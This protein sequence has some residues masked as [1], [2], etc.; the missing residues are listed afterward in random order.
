MEA[1]P[2]QNRQEVIVSLPL[3]VPNDDKIQ[4]IKNKL[5]TYFRSK[6]GCYCEVECIRLFGGDDCCP[7][8]RVV[9]NEQSGVRNVLSRPDHAIVVDGIKIA[10]K[11]QSS[12]APLGTL[13][14]PFSED[15]S[16]SGHFG[17][18][19]RAQHQ[20]QG[21]VSG[22]S[23]PQGSTTDTNFPSGFKGYPCP[24]QSRRKKNTQ[25]LFPNQ[26]L[27]NQFV[28]RMFVRPFPGGK[29][30]DQTQE[31]YPISF[32][33]DQIDMPE[34]T[35]PFTPANNNPHQAQT[36]STSAGGLCESATFDHSVPGVTNTVSGLNVVTNEGL[37][38]KLTKGS[39]AMET[40]DAI[41]NT[42]GSDLDMK[43][44]MVSQAIFQ[45][46]GPTLQ[47]E[48]DFWKDA[49]GSVAQ[50]SFI[51][52]GP[53]RLNCQKIYH[54]VC[55]GYKQFKSE[56]LLKQLVVNLMIYACS[57]GMTS[58]AIPA[59]GTGRLNYPPAV[60]AR[61]MYEAAF[62]FSSQHPN[63]SLKDV[64][65][66]VYDKDITAIKRFEDEIQ[67]LNPT[68][69]VTNG[70]ATGRVTGKTN[71]KSKMTRQK[72]PTEQR[73]R[74]EEITQQPFAFDLNNSTLSATRFEQPVHWKPMNQGEL[75][76]MVKLTA[77]TAEYTAVETKFRSSMTESFSH[78]V[79]VQRVQNTALLMQYRVHK[80]ALEIRLKRSDVEKLLF[81]GTDEQ[82]CNDISLRGFNRS[83]CGKNATMYG[84]GTY[85]AVQAGYSACS[86]FAKPN[87]CGTKH[88]L[89]SKV[90]VGDHTRG[91]P[92][93][94][95]PPPK[96]QN[97]AELFD[98]VVDN[99][100][101]P[102]IYVIFHDAQAYPEYVIKFK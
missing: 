38:I 101:T 57:D 15:P 55:E 95:D 71:K 19:P 76:E 28:G 56:Q 33:P 75:T 5:V 16:L 81:H 4:E 1:N 7:L 48:C 41:V 90:L 61:C 18:F 21:T 31:F 72:L 14:S 64:H 40:V 102:T 49:L 82:T 2:N 83:F 35:L 32:S 66:V 13:M 12:Q 59:L 63:G 25:R 58:M 44:G 34:Q 29:Q 74:E 77:G 46:A 99:M 69:S 50:W 85:F 10:F 6:W 3:I 68:S 67:R 98:S 94:R 70:G 73:L 43:N 80:S 88:I 27:K 52:T 26:P 24:T 23:T 8:Y 20:T 87:S 42:T 97:R 54:C 51:D 92:G 45:A 22:I 100:N 89:L 93:I 96:R 62:E 11:I 39:I 36:P 53:G 9:F 79:E 37:A 60:T 84:N 91:C 47:Q 86:Q 17:F 30:D 78:I 65:F